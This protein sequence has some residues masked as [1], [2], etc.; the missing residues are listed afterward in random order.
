MVH[1]TDRPSLVYFL[2]YQD[3]IKV[4]F[5]VDIVKRLKSFRLTLVGE[6]ELIGTINGGKTRERQVH[7]KLASFHIEGEWFRDCAAVRTAIADLIAFD[8][9]RAEMVVEDDADEAVPDIGP[10]NDDIFDEALKLHTAQVMDEVKA[11]KEW[12]ESRK[13]LTALLSEENKTVI[14]DEFQAVKDRASVTIFTFG[15]ENSN[16][17]EQIASVQ[18]RARRAKARALSLLTTAAYES[19]A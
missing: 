4:G 13:P 17:A 3:R 9:P 2:R 12:V 1:R 11:I 7:A 10:S 18:M 8:P 5:T 16:S 14:R 15:N 6:T 19:A